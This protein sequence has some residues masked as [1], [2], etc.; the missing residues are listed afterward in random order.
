MAGNVQKQEKEVLRAV[1]YRTGEAVAITLENGRIGGIGKLEG[2]SADEAAALPIAAPGLVDLQINGYCGLD[3]NTLPYSEGL[4]ADF[5]RKLWQEGVTSSYP[6]VITNSAAAIEE[7]MRSIANACREDAAVEAGV[8]GIHLE[9]PFITPEDG[10][11]GAHGRA[12]VGPPDWELFQ[13]WQEAAEGRI[14]IITLSPEWEG[15]PAFISRCAESGVVVSIGHTAATPEQI[16]EAVA[17]GARMSTHLGNG[18]HPMLQRHPNYI[19]EQLAQDRLWSCIIGDGFHL[20]EQVLKVFMKVKGEQAILVSDAVALS[21]LPPGEYETHVGG[22]VVLTPEGK[23]HLA[24]NDKILAGSAQ[25]LLFGIRH[26]AKS[27]LADWRDAWEMAS[28]R[29]SAFM[30]LPSAEGLSPGAPA[31]LALL[32]HKEDGIELV[33][34]YKSGIAVMKREALT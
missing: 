1:H 7:A 13:R 24:G 22:S 31:D 15:S 26:L 3:F 10:A 18:S 2:V 20:P 8:A 29:P 25:M 17:A 11:R 12:Y 21:G 33:G 28:I 27:G 34:T 5:I 30:G 6:T 16:A 14:R 4:A 9:G 23:L 19:W 32:R